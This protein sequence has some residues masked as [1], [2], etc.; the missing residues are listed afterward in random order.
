V[1]ILSPEGALVTI[2]GSG[3]SATANKN[4]VKFN[5]TIANVVA[6]SSTKITTIVPAGATT[7]RISIA[8]PTGATSTNAA[9]VVGAARAPT[10]ASFTP[11]IGAAGTPVTISGSNFEA[12]L[13]K[14]RF[15][16]RLATVSSLASNSIITSVPTNTT[17]GRIA[18]ATPYG[19]ALSD[20]DFFVPPVPFS[21]ADI[22]VTGRMSIGD[23]KTV[24]LGA[25]GKKGLILFDAPAG[26]AVTLFFSSVTLSGGSISILSPAG[27]VLASTTVSASGGFID[28]KILP[29][30]GTYTIL[31]NPSTNST[32][33]LT[34]TLNAV[35]DITGG[36]TFDGPA[37]TVTTAKPGQNASLTFDA[38]AGQ[39]FSMSVSGVKLTGGNYVNMSVLKPDG[40][41]LVPTAYVSSSG[42]F[43]DVRTIPVTGTYTIKLDPDAMAVGSMTAQLF[44]VG[45]DPTATIVI[46]G[47][48]MTITTAKPGQNASLTFSATAGQRF[49]MRVS[50]VKLAGG[51]YANMSILKPDGGTLVPT[52]YVTS[53]GTF[54]DAQTVPV[55]GTYTIKLNPDSMAVG[56]LTAQLFDVGRDPTATIV[57]GGPTV[58]VTTAQPGQNASLSFSAMAGQRF[59]LGVSGVKL[60]GGS[61]VNMSV[62][63]PD[64]SIL[65]PT[66][67][68][69]SSGTFIDA[70]TVPV[71]GIYSIK[72]NPDT[73]ATGSLTL[74]L[75]DI[76]QD[77]TATITI[78]GPAVTVSTVKPGQNASLTFSAI[79]GQ[80]FS[81]NV[82]GVKLT[83]G[84]YL[85]M[86]VLKPDGSILVPVAYVSS[87][88]TFIDVRTISVTGTYTIK[89][90][91]DS[92]AVGS[93]TMQ[94]FDIGSDPTAEITIGG[95]AATVVIAK[96]GQNASL[97][98]NG[99]AGQSATIHIPHTTIGCQTIGLRKPDGGVLIS[100][101]YCGTTFN[102]PP[103]TLPVAGVYT[104]TID[105]NSSGVGSTS[106]SLTGP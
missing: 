102:L 94:L 54:V 89:L 30:A 36:I 16:S 12:A 65:V 73:T 13:S 64:G 84:S 83:G 92:M 77:P 46:D 70:Q 52:A 74:Q 33:N 28:A 51:S 75:F 53:S 20:V 24:T 6:S 82:S 43:I 42:A 27:S 40:S 104:I 86:S 63:K 19:T 56:S 38:T 60:A 95:P 32:G 72:L 39:R 9:F 96:P 41:I 31:I 81:M 76:G 2:V 68:V 21:A 101:L 10:I 8:T 57:I 88:G 93:L 23:S 22:Q 58:T 80:R 34:L 66:T 3:F 85:S 100:S 62:I 106:I 67:Y 97:T 50:G 4:V 99:A 29:A 71:T 59:S 103:Q 15:N 18:V 44:D 55:T 45:Q 25:L 87:S 105:P 7:G 49:S 26:Q 79:E 91:P 47:P 61:Y 37:V 69:S 14:V 90:N 48:A 5:H 11:G 35:S 17:S 98:F 1:T 78:G